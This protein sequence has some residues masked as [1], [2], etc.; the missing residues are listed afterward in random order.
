[1][2]P[3]SKLDVRPILTLDALTCFA[4]GALMLLG[5]G[6]LSPLLGLPVGLLTV[7]G[8]MLMPIA[9]L[10]GWMSRQAAVSPVLLLLA[11]AGNAAWVVASLVVLFVCKPSLLG[12]AFV[13]G[14]AAVVAVLAMLEAR[15]LGRAPV[16][17]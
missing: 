7:A 10:F 2:N 8:A 17:A 11:V 9:A 4:A 16:S 14:Q 12:V 1:M 6:L 3:Q 5:A 15:G 13:A